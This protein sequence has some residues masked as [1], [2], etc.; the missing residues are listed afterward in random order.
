MIDLN[1]MYVRYDS[2]GNANG[3]GAS[4]TYYGYINQSQTSNTN[5]SD[6]ASVFSIK[7]MYWIGNVQY[8]S[9]SNNVVS[10]YES[11]WT[12]RILFFGTPSST[13][14]VTATSSYDGS[15]TNITF[16]WTAVAGVSRYLVSMNGGPNNTAITYLPDALSSA[17]LNPEHKSTTLQFVNQ[18]YCTIQNVATGSTYYIS[19]VPSNGY[20]ACTASTASIAI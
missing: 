16:N 12:N 13:T 14:T 4:A 15:K 3:T 18:N 8:T 17:V 6:S 20:G 9:W 2:V 7:K 1:S 5:P 11:D 10:A 19:V